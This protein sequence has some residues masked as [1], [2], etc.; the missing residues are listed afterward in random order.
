[1]DIESYTDKIQSF[2]NIGNFHAAVNIAISGLNECRRNNDQLCINKFLSIISGISLK[3]AHEFGSKEY[4]DKGEG[5][6]ICCFM[7]GATEDEAKLL[8]GAGGAICAKC[9]KDAYKHFSG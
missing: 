8:A 9:A 2:V 1:M 6:E 4:L 7:C 3:M 5:P